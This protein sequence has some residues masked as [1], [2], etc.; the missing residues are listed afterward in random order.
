MLKLFEHI[1]GCEPLSTIEAIYHYL[2]WTPS[3]IFSI[4]DRIMMNCTVSFGRLRPLAAAAIM[5]AVLLAAPYSA[6]AA[7]TNGRNL[8]IQTDNTTTTA[9]C[10][11][12]NDIFNTNSNKQEQHIIRILQLRVK[13]ETGFAFM[14]LEKTAQQHY[15]KTGVKIE[16][17]Y[18]TDKQLRTEELR[19]QLQN[20]LPVYDGFVLP[21]RLIVSMNVP[22]SS[23]NDSIPYLFIK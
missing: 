18:I 19:S 4:K 1:L 17:D 13:P 23:K 8:Q 10:E 2:G 15:E 5:I 12:N 16:F 14:G 22:C 9:E 7:D 20:K 6:D 21:S 11:C 3:H